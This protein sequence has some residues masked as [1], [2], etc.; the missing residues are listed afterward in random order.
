MHTTTRCGGEF[1]TILLSVP[2]VRI[3]T[4]LMPSCFGRGARDRP[5]VLPLIGH[6][7]WTKHF[8]NRQVTQQQ[9]R[10]H[11]NTHCLYS[12]YFTTN[13][14]SAVCFAE[15][16]VDCVC[17]SGG[18]RLKKGQIV[19]VR[20]VCAYVCVCVSASTKMRRVHSLL[21]VLLL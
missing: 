14:D 19:L 11:N 18:L 13:M 12:I 7:C 15:C 10:H 21:I 3:V 8:S 2:V 20:Q 5:F 9:H 17:E 6:H 16:T 4:C 1:W